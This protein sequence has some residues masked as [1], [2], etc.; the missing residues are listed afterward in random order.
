MASLSTNIII[1]SR[2]N[3]R[4]GFDSASRR[5][6]QLDKNTASTARSMK[7]VRLAAENVRKVLSVLA[8]G[9]VFVGVAASIIETADSMKLIRAKIA[10]VVESSLERE[11][12]E[13]RLIEISKAT[14][15]DLKANASLFNKVTV[16]TKDYGATT[17]QVLIFTEQLNKSLKIS[18]ATTVESASTVLQLGQA[19]AS[20]RLQGDEFRAVNEASTHTISLLAKEMGVARGALKS[21]SSA[22][23]IT[24]EVMFNALINSATETNKQFRQIPITVS[25]AVQNLS[26]SYQTFIGDTDKST[27][28]TTN[29][30]N[31]INVMADN[32]D[33]VVSVASTFGSVLA[34]SVV[35]SLIKAY[36]AKRIDTIITKEQI[37]LNNTIREQSLVQLRLDRASLT[38]S[39]AARTAEIALLEAKIARSSNARIQELDSAKLARMTKLQT[40]E[41]RQLNYAEERHT[42]VL[43]E[44]TI[45]R[46]R[47][48]VVTRAATAATGL[49]HKAFGAFILFDMSKIAAEWLHGFEEVRTGVLYLAEGIEVLKENL[50]ILYSP[51]EWFTNYRKGIYSLQEIHDEFDARRKVS[52]DEYRANLEKTKTI[53][54]VIAQAFSKQGEAKIHVSERLTKALGTQSKKMANLA[55]KSTDLNA[56][57]L[58]EFESHVTKTFEKSKDR[59]AKLTEELKFTRDILSEGGT[60]SLQTKFLV[61]K[62]AKLSIQLKGAK[63]QTKNF[64]REIK[65]FDALK[66]INIEKAY[67]SFGLTSHRSLEK[68]ASASREAFEVLKLGETPINDLASAFGKV[69][70]AETKAN[71]GIVSNSLKTEAAIYGVSLALN[72]QGELAV[73]SINIFHDKINK[74]STVSKDFKDQL[75]L[76]NAGNLDEFEESLS[77]NIEAV[78]AEA[79]N[80]KDELDSLKIK[81][82]ELDNPDT[83]EGS[84]LKERINQVQDKID[85]AEGRARKFKNT[86]DELDEVKL[87]NV[88]KAF[89]KLGLIAKSE[90]DRIAKNSQEAFDVVVKSEGDIDKL[91][92][93]FTKVANTSKDAND[94]IVSDSIKQQAIQNKLILTITEQGKVI[95]KSADE[96]DIFNDVTLNSAS[97]VN[98]LL[99]RVEN[100]DASS[101]GETF[102][103]SANVAN[104]EVSGIGKNVD[105]TVE[106]INQKDIK[107]FETSVTESAIETNKQIVKL[108]NASGKLA[109]AIDEVSSERIFELREAYV[110]LGIT[111]K[112]V[113]ANNIADA[114]EAYDKITNSGTA[115]AIEIGLAS[116]ELKK[117]IGDNSEE[118]VHLRGAFEALGIVS[119]KVLTDSALDAVKNYE[120]LKDSGVA[121]LAELEQASYRVKEATEAIA[122][123]NQLL[124]DEYST[125]GITS[126]DNL[127]LL[128]S[129]AKEAYETI[130]DS[131][132][133]SAED[134]SR[135]YVAS[136]GIQERSQQVVTELS[137]AYDDLGITSQKALVKSASDAQ[138]AYDTLKE[139]GTA[140][141]YELKEASLVV[142]EANKKLD[143][144]AQEL[145]D[146]Y[147]ALGIKSGESLR[148][149]ADEAKIAYKKIRDSGTA[150]ANDILLAEQAMLKARREST[151]VVDGLASAYKD[152]GIV[153]QKVLIEDAKEAS[154]AYDRLKESGKATFVELQQGMKALDAANRAVKD[155]SNEIAQ[156]YKTLGLDSSESLAGLA[157]NARQAYQRI[158][159]SGTA[160]A[161]DISRAYVASQ[162]VQEKTA[163]VVTELSDAYDKLGVTSRKVLVDNASDA[164]KA[165]RVLRG[166]GTATLVEL[167]QATLAVEEANNKLSDSTDLL[168]NDYKILGLESA[169]SLAELAKKAQEA[170]ENIRD[171]GTASAEDISSAF[172]A[173]Q[174]IQEQ[175]QSVVT[176]LSDAYDKLGIVSQ[177]VLTENAERAENALNVLKESGTATLFELQQASIVLANANKEIADSTDL[178]AKD[179]ETLGLKSTKA[180]Q[181][182]ADKATEAYERIRDSGTASANDILLAEQAMQKAH[183][184]TDVSVKEL[185]ESYTE[186]GVT[187]KRSLVDKVVDAEQAYKALKES[188]TASLFELQEATIAVDEAQDNL[189]ASTDLL[190]RDYQTLGLKSSK[191]LIDMATDAQSAYQRIRDSGTASAEEISRA[192]VASQAIQRNS[193]KVVTELTD[194]YTVLGI[195]SREAMVDGVDRASNAYDTLKESGTATLFELQQASI[196]LSEAKGKIADSVDLL[197]RD[198]ELLGIT[199]T[200]ALDKQADKAEEAYER[201]RDSGTASAND[202][203]LAEKAMEGA[204]DKAE[205]DIDEL[206]EAYAELGI[207]TRETLIENAIDAGRAYTALKESGKASLFELQQA[208]L[209]LDEAN[210]KLADS[211][212]LLAID[213]DTLGLKSSKTLRDMAFKAKK[214]Y[215]SIRDSGK[216][217]AEE[218]SRAFVAS[219]AIQKQSLKVVTELSNAYDELGIKSRKSLIE[220]AVEAGRAYEVLK[221]SGKASLFELQQASLVVADANKELAASTDL[222]AKDYKTLGIT[223]TKSIR[224]F[225]FE[226]KQAYERV[227]VSGKASA[228]EIALAHRSMLDAQKK[229]TNQVTDLSLAYDE[230]GIK[231][232]KVLIQG[233]LDAN[234]AYQKLK[235]SGTAT[236]SELEQ[237]TYRLDDANKAIADSTQLLTREYDALGIKTS[238]S[239]NKQAFE[240]K[241]AYEKIRDSGTASQSDI[242]R[243]FEKSQEVAKQTHKEIDLV[244]R[245]Y[246]NLGIATSSSFVDAEQQAIRSYET[247]KNSGTASANEI[248]L[249]YEKVKEAT[250]DVLRNNEG[251]AESFSELGVKSSLS[252]EIM[253]EKALSSYEAIRD[254]G[255]SSATDIQRAYSSMANKF[256]AESDGIISQQLLVEAAHANAVIAINK[257]GEAHSISKS[258]YRKKIVA[259]LKGD[260]ETHN[261]I[262][263][264]RATQAELNHEIRQAK[265]AYIANAIASGK[266]RKDVIEDANAIEK[267]QKAL[268][269]SIINDEQARLRAAQTADK[270]A[271]DS[272]KQM[273]DI[274]NRLSGQSTDKQIKDIKR[275]SSERKKA[276]EESMRD[277]R[278]AYKT[279]SD[280][281]EQ[282]IQSLDGILTSFNGKDVTNNIPEKMAR[283]ADALEQDQVET[284]AQLG[285][286]TKNRL[287]QADEILALRDNILQ[288]IQRL[289]A[290]KKL[291]QAD[292]EKQEELRKALVERNKITSANISASKADS[293]TYTE[294]LKQSTNFQR[295][296]TTHDNATSQLMAKRASDA[297]KTLDNVNT[298]QASITDSLRAQTTSTV[299]ANAENVKQYA[300]QMRSQDKHATEMA[301]LQVLGIENA[302][303]YNEAVSGKQA[304]VEAISKAHIDAMAISRAKHAASL[305]DSTEKANAENAKQY[306]DQMRS[307]KNHADE[308]LRLHNLRATN[309]ANLNSAIAEKQAEVEAISKAHIEAY[310]ASRARF[311]ASQLADMGKIQAEN[312]KQLSDQLRSDKKH[313]DEMAR[314]HS[315]SVTNAKNYNEAV[316]ARRKEIQDISKH[317]LSNSS[318][319][320][321][322]HL[323]EMT[324][325]TE[326]INAENARQATSLRRS[327]TNHAN[328]MAR[329]HALNVKN[330]NDYNTAVEQRH[331]EIEAISKRL[332][333]AG[334]VSKG[335]ADAE[336]QAKIKFEREADIARNN[337]FHENRKQDIIDAKALNDKIN[338]T[339][340]GGESELDRIKK[341]NEAFK[342]RKEN[343][344]K[345]KIEQE[346]IEQAR[347]A[348]LDRQHEAFLK[349]KQREQE[350]LDKK[351]Q[352]ATTKDNASIIGN[353]VKKKREEIVSKPHTVQQ[354]KISLD[355]NL[356]GRT[357]PTTFVDNAETR[358]FINELEQSGKLI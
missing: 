290:N 293:S 280:A 107:T 4:S 154:L 9:G 357:V 254:S 174:V 14:R 6:K 332:G 231:S 135:A 18:G 49:L 51:T 206:S 200:K 164:E 97:K 99:D 337:K 45:A 54:A 228:N 69:A 10:L 19:L 38:A 260:L 304:E 265:K 118:V 98:E 13:K 155:S 347:L 203:L 96:F 197:A 61:D 198:Y 259:Q 278:R 348:E 119:N 219:Q 289:S 106:S 105:E 256:L 94:G 324:A 314:L 141:L 136:L 22:G 320:Q 277:A 311:A 134:V 175:S 237:A 255:T 24:T 110:G 282:A 5:L 193:T 306:A 323:A 128:A 34:G 245:A 238:E 298:S 62:L 194:A 35:L 79:T 103:K 343:D 307:E 218:I 48:T 177:K 302:K 221:K 334:Q 349:E 157:I 283:W 327:A 102:V 165:Y 23:K 182:H 285:R 36:E 244:A 246:N 222:L 113:M 143:R 185:T 33:H 167:E 351:R 201:I 160:S 28:A 273:R 212:D 312:A 50:K 294:S 56:V 72:D 190:A 129:E 242:Q 124:T 341:R 126:G 145:A 350:I 187:S 68:T 74:L 281:S 20:G 252:L 92:K 144:S 53:D 60:G 234:N 30:A 122:K 227:K 233:A 114:K 330:A 16:A 183:D 213:Y 150:S 292:A 236:L 152:L 58:N 67:T 41:L 291:V 224:D 180:L 121:S 83:L 316:D 25:G 353:V 214:A 78:T 116:K 184:A 188:G 181:D 166:S 47:N 179:Y 66:L 57:D 196:A 263:Q 270:R 89:R 70:I 191:S 186:L 358:A 356:N 274:I 84:E 76:T 315:L 85:Q 153:S 284:T 248:R 225:A 55:K 325:R 169:D 215:A 82:K 269:R 313:S 112:E 140:T 158:R 276:T 117:V 101:L 138:K 243:A 73:Q 111:S 226:A 64:G 208:T 149:L 173:S 100:A 251:L 192:Y 308:M 229:V 151:D 75:A 352:V 171:S 267:A 81:L 1:N 139:S 288:G 123:S 40:T 271:A 318:A 176:E 202:I 329:I 127:K 87:S 142:E 223:S 287:V 279:Q 91:A 335:K 42:R 137:K 220:S 39:T 31:G 275:V 7:Q 253:K 120:I 161:E 331:K 230:L 37:V 77:N 17:E 262:Q 247:I 310:A 272:A 300:D 195:T 232:R 354:K 146:E 8:V 217:S 104:E 338:K 29:L 95:A 235:A 178:L 3:T 295:S 170:Y 86:L 163:N 342:I 240:A 52:T 264:V 172:V 15:S 71:N 130:R 80:F 321:A 162:R 296:R 159:D 241:Q 133:A 189:I 286:L 261:S 132:V 344:E 339:L 317:Q 125:L 109:V 299:A 44:A 268:V 258:A 319:S 346:R 115:S 90:L 266:M 305:L 326:R 11:V 257:E 303:G 156:D 21:L 108:A 355:L 168:I 207:T 336:L 205:N 32:F 250:Y 328:E 211:T 43:N 216:A 46:Q 309:A 345:A 340:E 148:K 93:A 88:E 209:A 59:V 131:G 27:N 322:K 297:A 2:D 204:R 239:L 63:S 147:K 301:R 199:S 333:E 12:V 65:A 249:A 210:G 26:T